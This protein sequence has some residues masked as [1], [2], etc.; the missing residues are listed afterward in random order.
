MFQWLKNRFRAPKMEDMPLEF[1]VDRT[2]SE[3][4]AV[5]VFKRINGNKIIKD[6]NP[7]CRYGYREV[8]STDEGK[9][10]YVVSPN[11][12]QT[13]LSL[14][15]MNPSLGKNGELFEDTSTLTTALEITDEITVYIE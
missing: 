10:H 15:S 6:I 4:H 12:R 3:Q 7:L 9:I 1:V 2:E 14:K 8:Y 5:K 13:L 11:D